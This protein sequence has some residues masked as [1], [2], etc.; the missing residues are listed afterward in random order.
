MQIVRIICVVLILV[1]NVYAGISFRFTREFASRPLKNGAVLYCPIE[2]SNH[3]NKARLPSTIEVDKDEDGY[4]I[5]KKI[6]G[7]YH[8]MTP[9][10]STELRLGVNLI[11]KILERKNNE[12]IIVLDWGCGQGVALKQLREFFMNVDKLQL[13][14]LS[15]IAYRAWNKLPE[16]ISLYWMPAEDMITM[17]LNGKVDIIYTT[18]GIHH[19]FK[20]LEQEEIKSYLSDIATVLKDGGLLLLDFEL[21][22]SVIPE[23]LEIYKD[24]LKWYKKKNVGAAIIIIGYP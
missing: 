16:D 18:Y 5:N 21:D 13:I 17:G 9:L 2:V 15:D 14:G 8:E 10:V 7:W 4:S 6:Y 11:D 1:Y 22:S 19:H 23:E 24:N 12:S 20:N 3:I